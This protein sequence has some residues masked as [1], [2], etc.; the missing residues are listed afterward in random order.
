[1]RFSASDPLST[2]GEGHHDDGRSAPRSVVDP[3]AVDGEPAA[4]T[5][6]T[7]SER[8]SLWTNPVL[9]A[10]YLAERGRRAPRL[11]R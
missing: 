4:L 6:L 7:P 10:L 1:M 2:T 8:V 3:A 5:R 9:S 11:V